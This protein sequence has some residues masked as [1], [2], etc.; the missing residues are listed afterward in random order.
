[1]R[2]V[3]R[4]AFLENVAIFKRDAKRFE[5]GMFD[6]KEQGNVYKSISVNGLNYI[7]FDY[8]K[9]EMMSGSNPKFKT[10]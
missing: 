3:T 10:T 7:T 8:P 1:M 5:L 6:V 4:K 9:L 2:K